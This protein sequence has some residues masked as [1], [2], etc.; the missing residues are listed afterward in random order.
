MWPLT[1]FLRGLKKTFIPTA[2]VKR[3]LS[4]D[5][6]PQ[7]WQLYGWRQFWEIE[8]DQVTGTHR[9]AQV[10]TS[11]VVSKWVISLP[12]SHQHLVKWESNRWRGSQEANLSHTFQAGQR[13]ESNLGES[14]V[15][16]P[17]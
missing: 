5:P 1:K 11:L 16:S 13:W 17:V 10:V 15:E 7:L 8:P 6:T 2:E 14:W 12:T 9:A 4:K 3:H